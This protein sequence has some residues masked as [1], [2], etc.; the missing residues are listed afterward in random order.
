[1]RNV[2]KRLIKLTLGLC[3]FV[4][5]AIALALTSSADGQAPDGY[6]TLDL[7]TEY[8]LTVTPEGYE[9]DRDSEL[10][11]HT[12]GYILTGVSRGNIYFKN[13]DGEGVTY[14]VI[15]HNL[16]GTAKEWYGCVVIDANVTLNLVVYGDSKLI[17]Y[18]HPGILAE[19]DGVVI[20]ITVV[21]GSRLEVG[22]DFDTELGCIGGD[23]T[24][25]ILSGESSLDITDDGWEHLLDRVEF[26]NGTLKSHTI[27]GEKIDD[28]SCLVGCED[29]ELFTAIK[30]HSYCYVATGNDTN[31]SRVCTYCSDTIAEQHVIV[32]GLVDNDYHES[33]CSSCDEILMYG[34]HTLVDG[35][36]TV[37]EQE[38]I[39]IHKDESGNERGFFVF[40]DAINYAKSWGGTLVL[41][42]DINAYDESINADY[43]DYTFDFNGYTI[44]DTYICIGGRTDTATLTVTDTS[45]AKTGGIGFSSISTG[46]YGGTLNISYISGIRAV[47]VDSGT[48]ILNSTEHGLLSLSVYNGGTA[49]LND[50]T[51]R[52]LS[53]SLYSYDHLID[54]IELM[55]G[56]FEIVKLENTG[57]L[58][59][60]IIDLL[61][62]GYALYDAYGN[63]V[64]G[65]V[66]K[67]VGKTSISQHT[68]DTVNTINASATYYHYEACG[69][70]VQVGGTENHDMGDDGRCT[71]CSA[72]IAAAISYDDTILYF[73]GVEEAFGEIPTGKS[74]KITIIRLAM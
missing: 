41:Q 59:I 4:V 47:F 19:G 73:A 38:L 24:I 65:G 14:D 48:V 27:K 21:D 40:T 32:Y 55:G 35:K 7:N 36:C 42:R 10:T 43:V 74:T 60:G 3:A 16:D 68:H 23:P 58:D 69:C 46:V 52:D 26:T 61:K 67:I 12:G 34:E 70:G 20:N 5:F 31:H 30:E 11:S 39:L 29:C 54:S 2:T 63:V 22:Y 62:D 28:E 1:M 57:A 53:L 44:E 33:Y 9:I 13:N 17:G 37:C 6:L 72:E 8:S 25:N 15:L 51:A 45:D 66:K 18:N 49:K 56:T 64:N 50:I 71:V